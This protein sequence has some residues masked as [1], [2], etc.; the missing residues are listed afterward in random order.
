[1]A[2]Y[3]IRNVEA[4][5]VAVTNDGRTVMPSAQSSGGSSNLHELSA[6]FHGPDMSH[7]QE[8]VLEI[9]PFHWGPW[10]HPALMAKM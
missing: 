10:F 5:I 4:R 8:F 3:T 2:A 7:V 6:Q 1:M 9:R